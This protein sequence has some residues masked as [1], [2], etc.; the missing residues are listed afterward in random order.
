MCLGRA[1]CT[2]DVADDV[3]IGLGLET[4][5]LVDVTVFAMVGEVVAAC[6]GDWIALVR[7]DSQLSVI[8]LW[9]QG[10]CCFGASA[11]LDTYR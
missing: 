11:K 9:R 8:D 1:P 7:A 10:F 6:L 3:D 4:G 2:D 5:R